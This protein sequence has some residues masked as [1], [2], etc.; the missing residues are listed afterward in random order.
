MHDVACSFGKRAQSPEVSSHQAQCSEPYSRELLS[1]EVGR[2]STRSGLAIAEPRIHEFTVGLCSLVPSKRCLGDFTR[3]AGP[4]VNGGSPQ[5]SFAATPFPW[6]WSK[7]NNKCFVSAWPKMPAAPPHALH[8]AQ[9]SAFRSTS[10]GVTPMRFSRLAARG[11]LH[12]V[13]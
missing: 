10:T 13:R 11:S 12:G 8:K 3:K 6:P 4:G 1:R 2:R 5:S 9:D 7:S